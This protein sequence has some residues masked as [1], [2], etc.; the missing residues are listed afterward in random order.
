MVDGFYWFGDLFG[1]QDI[2]FL[3]AMGIGAE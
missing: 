1:D 2:F 3:G